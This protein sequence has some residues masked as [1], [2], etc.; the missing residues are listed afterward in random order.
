MLMMSRARRTWVWWEGSER[1]QS[2]RRWRRW[3]MVLRP[4]S[5]PML[6]W[7]AGRRKAEKSE[8]KCERRMVAERWHQ[9]V[10]MPSC[11]MQRAPS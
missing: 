10:P 11:P 3:E 6:N 8:W 9:A 4:P 1:W 7:P 5:M 2:T